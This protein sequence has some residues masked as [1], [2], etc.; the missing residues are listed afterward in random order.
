MASLTDVGIRQGRLGPLSTGSHC[1]G[2]WLGLV[3]MKVEGVPSSKKTS[4]CALAFPRPLLA[5]CL[6]LSH[7]LK[8]VTWLSPS[9]T[10]KNEPLEGVV[11]H[12]AEDTYRDGR[13][14]WPVL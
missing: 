10:G 8:Q 3:H 6:L 12:T 9:M 1:P 2:P 4:P 13:N 14:L 11:S 7:W 5:S